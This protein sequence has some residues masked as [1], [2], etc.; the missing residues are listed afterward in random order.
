[1]SADVLKGD[2]QE[3]VSLSHEDLSNPLEFC[4]AIGNCLSLV[5]SFN[6]CEIEVPCDSSEIIKLIEDSNRGAD[7]SFEIEVQKLQL[8]RDVHEETWARV[9]GKIPFLEKR[10]FEEIPGYLKMKDLIFKCSD[11]KMVKT[12]YCVKLIGP[13]GDREATKSLVYFFRDYKILGDN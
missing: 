11:G 6:T 2:S 12:E 4:G 9:Q 3:S 13:K 10:K 8:K 7:E 5:R 1:M